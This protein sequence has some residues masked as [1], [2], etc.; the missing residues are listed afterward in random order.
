MKDYRA[1]GA[2]ERQQYHNPIDG[3]YR[4]QALRETLRPL[5]G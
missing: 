2:A 3:D 1:L 5:V 4:L